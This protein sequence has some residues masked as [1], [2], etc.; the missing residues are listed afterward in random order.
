MNR[1]Q[2]YARTRS[3]LLVPRPTRRGFLG[4]ALG[5]LAVA[6]LPS[7]A[8]CGSSGGSGDRTSLTD[9]QASSWES[10]EEMEKWLRF[11]GEYF[12]AE[13]PGVD[14]NIDY[15]IPFND[16]FPTLQTTIAGGGTLDMCWMHGRFVPQF[17]AAGLIEPLDDLIDSAAPDGWPDEYFASQIEGFQFDG[18]QYGMPYDIVAG[19]MYV[20]VDWFDRA[21][22]DLPT[23]DWTLDDLLEAAITLKE[24]A[25]DPDNSWAMTLPVHTV[26]M[27]WLVRS[28]GGDFFTDNGSTSHLADDG[29]IAAVQYLV[30]AMHRYR[31]MPT[32]GDLNTVDA[33]G[34]GDFALF[35]SE[36]I[37]ILT[38]INDSAFVIDDFVQGKFAWTVAPTPRGPEG[39][40]QQVGGSAF[41]L[42]STTRSAEVSFEVMKHL[43]ANP[44]TLPEISR[45]GSLV[46][47]RIG[48]GE[49][50]YPAEDVVPREAFDAAF[51]GPVEQDGVVLTFHERY[52]E[53]EASV[54]SVKIDELWTGS[55]DD[56]PEVMREM[57]EMTQDLIGS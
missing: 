26:Q 46:P 16:Y 20:N 49:N 24:A 53:W 31:V 36:R 21:G 38:Q 9:W 29:T 13:Q 54:Y 39:R 23:A 50:A 18:Q 51:F 14:W 6:G 34:A 52:A 12:D 56:V 5:A 47:A 44:D 55:R 25:P 11:T 48:F 1:E 37:A 28:F 15:G 45:M 33:G 22:V 35:G 7:L 27:Y 40:F 57:D 42:P 3:G 43:M 2:R 4:G 32:P 19:G 30:D 17:A 41:A 10:A 8:G